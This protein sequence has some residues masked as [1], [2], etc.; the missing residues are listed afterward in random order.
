[1]LACQ[2]VWHGGRFTRLRLVAG[3]TPSILAYEWVEIS[4]IVVYC[5]TG[6]DL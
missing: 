1:M 3:L 6:G 4:L 5:N 2:F